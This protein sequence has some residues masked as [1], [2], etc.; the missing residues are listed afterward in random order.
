MYA[1]MGHNRKR[2][3]T[4]GN[5]SRPSSPFNV[6]FGIGTVRYGGNAFWYLEFYGNEI[7]KS[8]DFLYSAMKFP[9]QDCSFLPYRS[10]KPN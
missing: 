3:R 2:P 10:Q 8:S 4:T 1:T 7:I 9:F 5:S 6:P